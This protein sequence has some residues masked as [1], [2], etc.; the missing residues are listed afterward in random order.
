MKPIN[1]FLKSF[2][3]ALGVL[4]Y[5]STIAFFAFNNSGVFGNKP[6]MLMPVFALMLF[7]VSALITGMLVL[8]QP[9]QLYLDGLKKEAVR[10]LV[11]TLLWLVIFLMIVAN[12][13]MLRA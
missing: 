2:L 13:L 6:S 5:V 10:L 1:Y 11:A 4:V 12:V 3:S 7:I 8:G 9:I